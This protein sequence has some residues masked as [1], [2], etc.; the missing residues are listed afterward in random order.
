MGA[1]P[2]SVSGAGVGVAGN[3]LNLA[4]FWFIFV[5]GFILGFLGYRWIWGLIIWARLHR[6]LDRLDLNTVATHPDRAGGLGFMGEVELRFG[7][8]AFAIGTLTSANLANNILFEG[9]TLGA[10]MTILIAFIV[11]GPCARI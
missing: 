8:L 10:Q 2:P 9:S 11:V 3:G 1:S 5:S 7:I 4:G 6:R